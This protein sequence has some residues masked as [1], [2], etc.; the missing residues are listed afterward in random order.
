MRTLP[1]ATP[2]DTALILLGSRS[3]TATVCPSEVARALARSRDGGDADWR[4]FM[5]EVHDA[6]DAMVEASLVRLRWKGEVCPV[7]AGPYRLHRGRAFPAAVGTPVRIAAESVNRPAASNL[8]EPSDSL[9][10]PASDQ[11]DTK[12]IGKPG[13]HRRRQGPTVGCGDSVP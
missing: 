5:P 12:A 4:G 7:R 10:V 6:V 1:E 11:Q 13:R 9:R 8:E 3:E 2:F